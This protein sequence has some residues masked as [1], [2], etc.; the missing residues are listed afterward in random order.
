MCLTHFTRETR[1]SKW[2]LYIFFGGDDSVFLLKDTF[3]RRNFLL[4]FVKI[5]FLFFSYLLRCFSARWKIWAFGSQWYASVVTKYVFVRFLKIE[6]VFELFET[7]KHASISMWSSCWEARDYAKNRPTRNLTGCQKFENT[8]QKNIA[9]ALNERVGN[10]GIT[11]IQEMKFR[12]CKKKI[13]EWEERGI[14][15]IYKISFK[16]AWYSWYLPSYDFPCASWS[17]YSTLFS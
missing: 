16:V 5:S 2:N 10:V 7:E 14:V 11:L 12:L 15:L 4:A 1:R 8:L 9:S 3:C 13:R 6:S 17:T